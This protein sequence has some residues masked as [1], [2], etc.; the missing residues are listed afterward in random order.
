MPTDEISSILDEDEK[1]FEA[2]LR[3]SG[4]NL[5]IEETTA[6]LGIEPTDVL[7]KGERR[8]G[9]Y[10]ICRENVWTWRITEDSSEP[11]EQQFERSLPIIERRTKELRAIASAADVEAYWFLGF[12]SGNGQG[13]ATFSPQLL[14]RLSE[15]GLELVLDLYPEVQEW[16]GD[17]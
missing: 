4:E 9:K 17:A 11:F 12:S 7:R 14:A 8:R 2:A 10:A 13:M 6:K 15:L 16:R 3:I 1:W 5:S